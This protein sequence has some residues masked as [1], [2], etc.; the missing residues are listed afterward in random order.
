MILGIGNDVVSIARIEEVKN[1][2]K[3]KFLQKI[4]T[5]NEV[6]FAKKKSSSDLFFAKRFAAKEAFSKAVGLGIGRGINFTDIEIV[7]DK[8]GKPEIK[9][10]N[11]KKD[12]LKS[13]F[14][15]EDF[16]IHLSLSDEKNFA[17][18]MVVIEKKS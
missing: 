12:F 17:S 18:A 15:C 6:D 3:E 10:L 9:I 2:F 11:N 1:Q 16:A 7:N 13:H 14:G 4:F 5:K 8:F